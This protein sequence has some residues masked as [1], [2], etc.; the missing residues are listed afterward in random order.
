MIWKKRLSCTVQLICCLPAIIVF[1]PI[2]IVLFIGFPLGIG[3]SEPSLLLLIYLPSIVF[4]TILPGLGC[5]GL[6]RA[7]LTHGVDIIRSWLLCGI[8]P[9][10]TGTLLLIANTLS[11]YSKKKSIYDNTPAHSIWENSFILIILLS[12]LSCILLGS[13]Y[14]TR[15]SRIHTFQPL[16]KPNT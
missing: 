2:A 6:I 14:L 4:F 1:I 9:A 7:I 16:P 3:M 15:K 10:I 13:Y 12:L 5:M 11:D 8:I